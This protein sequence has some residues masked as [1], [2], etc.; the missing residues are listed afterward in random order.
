MQTPTIQTKPTK[1]WLHVLIDD[2]FS[3]I[4]MYYC[5]F[6]KSYD[7]EFYQNYDDVVLSNS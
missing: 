4:I 5:D 1:S 2:D 6:S 3:K 7:L